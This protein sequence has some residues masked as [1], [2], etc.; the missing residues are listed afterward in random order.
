[1]HHS[2]I[3]MAAL[4]RRLNAGLAW[5]CAALAGLLPALTLYGLVSAGTPAW[6]APLL[7]AALPIAP[8]Q[9]L[10]AGLLALLP[11]CGMAYGL[12]RARGCFQA[13]ARAEVLGLDA[14]RHLRGLA[15]GMVVAA[16]AGLLAPT[17]IGLLLSLDAPA[18]QR[19][20]S[21]SL[22]STQC[23]LLLFAGLVWQIAQV[24]TQAAALADE[25]AQI[26]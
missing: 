3:P 13:F 1:M 11:V 14:V 9:T 8:W 21:L 25:H 26:V 20:L 7:A 24:M 10:L 19:R 4:P 23:L 5:A 17:L 12:W 2:H 16:L 18:G 22:G 15:L 6:H